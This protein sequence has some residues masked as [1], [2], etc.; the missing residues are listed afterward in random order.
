MGPDNPGIPAPDDDV[1]SS[2]FPGIVGLVDIALQDIRKEILPTVPGWRESMGQ[3]LRCDLKIPADEALG[4]PA[5]TVSV[6]IQFKEP[7]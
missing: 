1:T 2:K 6:K 7:T 4:T 3:P 5:F